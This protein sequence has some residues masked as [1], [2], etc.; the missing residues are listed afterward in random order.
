MRIRK[1]L[2]DAMD[3]EGERPRLCPRCLERKVMGRWES[4][5]SFSCGGCH[6]RAIARRVGPKVSWRFL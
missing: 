6:L 5:I 1:D 3:V 4:W 2:M